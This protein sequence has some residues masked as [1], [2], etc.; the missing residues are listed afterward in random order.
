MCK[1]MTSVLQEK[2]NK[3]LQKMNFSDIFLVYMQKK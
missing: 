2:C 3:N 1:C